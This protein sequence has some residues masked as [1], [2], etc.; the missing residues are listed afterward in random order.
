MTV[1]YFQKAAATLPPAQAWNSTQIYARTMFDAGA[2]TPGA[3]T[4]SA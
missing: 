2:C 4:A 1:A 3:R